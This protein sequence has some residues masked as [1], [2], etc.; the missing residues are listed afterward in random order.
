MISFPC[1]VVDL[2]L[3]GSDH[4]DAF[5]DDL[6]VQ[7]RF[8]A[9]ELAKHGDHGFKVLVVDRIQTVEILVP[10]M[11]LEGENRVLGQLPAF[12][13]VVH[14]ESVDLAQP[15]LRPAGDLLRQGVGPLLDLG[16]LHGDPAAGVAAQIGPP[17]LNELELFSDEPLQCDVARSRPRRSAAGCWSRRPRRAHVRGRSPCPGRPPAARRS[18]SSRRCPAR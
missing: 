8:Q 17:L 15:A 11:E 12:V 1:V 7:R 10:P 2:L 13:E 4:V 16:D 5:A 6:T 14:A 9:V 3:Q 18:N